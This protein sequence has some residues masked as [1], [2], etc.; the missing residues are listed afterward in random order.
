MTDDMLGNLGKTINNQIVLRLTA[1]IS[2]VRLLVEQADL[3]TDKQQSFVALVRRYSALLTDEINTVQPQL[4]GGDHARLKQT[5]VDLSQPVQELQQHLDSDSAIPDR[6]TLRKLQNQLNKFYDAMRVSITET[7]TFQ[8]VRSESDDKKSDITD[9]LDL[10]DEEKEEAAAEAEPDSSGGLPDADDQTPSTKPTKPA[11][12]IAPPQ[13]QPAPVGRLDTGA[14]AGDDMDDDVDD[15]TGMSP[16]EPEEEES[17]SHA[18][19]TLRRRPGGIAERAA[20]ERQRREEGKARTRDSDVTQTHLPAAADPNAVKVAAYYPKEIKPDDWQPLK[21]YVFRTFAADKVA[22][23]AG[24]Q[25]GGL[26]AT[27]RKV[28]RSV[29]RTLQ[30]GATVT[31]SPTLPGFQFNPPQADVGFYEDWHRADFKLR[32]VNAEKLVATNGRLTFSVEGVI[33]ADLPLSVYVTDTPSA[34]DSTHNS[35]AKLYQSIFCSYSHDD[36]HIVERVERAYKALGMEFLRDVHSLKAGEDWDNAL[37]RLIEKAD[38]FQLFWSS[39]AASSDHVR[40]EWEHAVKLKRESFIRPV[41][42]EQ[43][44]P[45]VPSALNAVHFAF[46]PDLV[47]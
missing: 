3:S 15:F 24:K 10:V 20:A 45:P 6:E 5:L 40:R 13:P 14:N 2:T 19:D 33:V 23:D 41:Y 22:E 9:L 46:Q 37:I 35:E 25:L 31:I 7:G 26:I 36:A 29:G 4:S 21:A 43:P 1:L 27:M 12:T 39:T 32:A 28:I 38:I 18:D 44:M 42:W 17:D 30:D 11:Q 16:P 47:K 34:A 8:I